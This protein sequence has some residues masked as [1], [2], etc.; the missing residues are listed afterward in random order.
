VRNDYT[1]LRAAHDS[2]HEYGHPI[3]PTAPQGVH[4]FQRSRS[5][6]WLQ[7]QKLSNIHALSNLQNEA[8]AI[9]ARARAAGNMVTALLK[10]AHASSITPPPPPVVTTPPA[11]APTPPP[12][13]SIEQL[14]LRCA[15][16]CRAA[17]DVPPRRT[18]RQQRL[19]SLGRHRR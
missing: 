9:A 11:G 1:L 2:Q 3:P 8:S 16:S 19:R 7:L 6:L 13:H 5:R 18:R 15:G 10:M 4:L 14:L 12:F 17:G